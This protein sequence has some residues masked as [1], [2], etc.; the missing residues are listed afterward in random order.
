MLSKSIMKMTGLKRLNLEVSNNLLSDEGINNSLPLLV[1]LIQMEELRLDFGLYI[2][3]SKQIKKPSSY[4]MLRSI[5]HSYLC[6][7]KIKEIGS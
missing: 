3:I 6:N 7:A 5:F 4:G 1:N 2:Y